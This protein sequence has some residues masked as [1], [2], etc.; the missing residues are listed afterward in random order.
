[1]TAVLNAPATGAPPVGWLGR[2]RLLNGSAGSPLPSLSRD[3]LLALLDAVN[4]T[5]RG[6]AAFPLAAK[7]RGLRTGTEPVVVVN[8]IEGEPASAKDAVLLGR[9]PH[10]VFDGA[11]VLAAAVG[12]SRVLVAIASSG[13]APGLLRALAERPDRA[14]FQ[15]HG[16]E[17]RFVAG[18][19]RALI[20]ALNGGPAVP[21]GRLVLPT[22]R[23]VGGAPT[24]L[25]NAETFAQLAVVSRI[26]PAAFSEVGTAS[27]PGTTLLTVTGAVARP[28]VLEIPLGT[29]LGAVA[30]A[31]G[32]EPSDA[33]V[34]G[35]YHGAWLRYDPEL[36]LSRAGLAA[37]GGTL[38]AGAVIFVGRQTCALAELARV[39][40]WL[41]AQSAKQCGPC[42]F[43]LPALAAD[44]RALQSGTGDAELFAR[45][46][47]QVAGRGACAHPDG[48][49]RFIASGLRVLTEEMGV[50]RAYGG[51]RRS[52]RGQLVTGGVR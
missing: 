28:G 24:V 15:L 46:A 10:V 38:G 52:D 51:C 40:R 45:H 13:Q 30:A 35:G 2:P 31:V 22:V 17:D 8:G 29:S 47:G 27:E 1:M 9:V 25:A 48:A 20:S 50:H 19:S 16:V 7:I 11:A 43:G 26:G 14:L 44:V 5:G 41:A 18:E 12:A 34:I 23:G 49:V 39:A 36:E 6:G 32:A 33:V 3:G 37:A 4:L 42:A 21:P